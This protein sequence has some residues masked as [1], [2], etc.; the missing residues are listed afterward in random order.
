M[1]DQSNVI[2]ETSSAIAGL[3][4][5]RTLNQIEKGKLTYAL[6]ATIENFDGQSVNYQNEPGNELCFELPYGY[7]YNGG[8]FIPELTKHIYFL[9][10]PTTGDSEIGYMD[11]NNC[12]YH[13]YINDP[14]LAFDKNFPILKVAHRQTDCAT[15]IYW[16]DAHNSRRFLDLNN[17]P[18]K[19]KSG[20]NVCDNETVS[21]IDCNKLRIQP[22]YSIPNIEIKGIVNGGTLLAGTVQFGIQYSDA[23]GNPYTQYYSITNPTPI[24]NKNIISANFNYPVGKSVILN[25]TDIE[26]SGYYEYFNLA[27]IKTINDITSVELIGTYF[28]DN[29]E[30]QIIYNGQNQ[31]QI[32]L[33][34]DDVFRK[35]P[36]YDV[37]GDLTVV[38]DVIVWDQLSSVERVN[39]QKIANQIKLQWQTWRIPADEDYTDEYNATN[40][41]GQLRDEVYPYEIVFLLTNGKETDGFH[42]PGRKLSPADISYGEVSPSNPDFI[43]TPDPDTGTSPYW[44]IYN[45]ATV[46]ETDPSYVPYSNYKGPY[47]AGDFSYWESTELYPCNEEVWGE[48]AN[49]PIRHH[50]FPDVLISPI[51]ENPVIEINPDGTYGNLAIQKNA[52]FPI[53]VRINAQEIQ[54]LI[55]TSELTEEEKNQIVGFKIVRG[56]RSTNKSIIAKGILR[57]VGKYEREGTE[58]YFPNYPYNDLREDPFLLNQ[59]N[60]YSSECGTYT[61]T[62]TAD[63]E[64][65]FTNCFK[66]TPDAGI[67]FS[68]EPFDVCS[69]TKPVIL[70][71]TATIAQINFDT[72]VIKG[73][74]DSVFKIVKFRYNKFPKNIITESAVG[75]TGKLTIKVIK[76]STIQVLGADGKYSITQVSN[77]D[78]SECYPTRLN[79]F[80]SD[81]SK[82][83]HVFNSPETSFGQPFLGSVLKV[84]NVIFGSGKAHYTE[85]KKNAL[86]KLLTREAQEDALASSSKIADITGDFSSTAMF[87][88]Y[89]AYL[90]IYTN[91]ITRRN[92]GWSYNS[93]LDYD[94]YSNVNNGVGIK[95]RSLSNYQYLYPGVQSVNDN[96]NIN[97][98]QRE[99]SVYL[100]TNESVIPLPYPSKTSS[101]LYGEISKIEDKSRFI[102]SEI[103]CS[104]PENQFDISSVLYYASIKDIL[105]NQWGQ[106][107]SYETIDTGL[108]VKFD[109]KAYIAGES[110]IKYI[111]GGDTFI[112]KFSFKS[113]LPFFI[114]NRVNAPDDSDIYYD[115][116]GNIAYPEYWHSARSILFDYDDSRTSKLKNIISIKAHNFDCPNNQYP[117][118]NDD[119]DPP[120]VNP[121]RTF[122]DGKMYMF[123]YGIPTFHVE[124]SINVELRQAVNNREGDFYPHVSSGIPDDWVQ[125]SF[126]PIVQDNTYIYNVTYSKQNE[127]NFFSHLPVDFSGDLCDT[128]YPYRAIFSEDWL[129]YKAL[130]YF[131]FPQ[132]FGKLTSIDG[133]E[134]RSILARFENKSLLYNTLLTIDTSNPKA[135]Y[136]GGGNLFNSSPPVDFAETDL[137]YVGSQNKFLLKLPQGQLTVDAKRGQVFLITG[138]TANDI[139]GFESGL[140]RFLKDHLPFEILNYFSNIN[141]DNHFNGIGLHGVYDSKY[142]RVIITK[143]DYIPTSNKV[144]YDDSTKEFY[145]EK[146]YIQY[147]TTLSKI[148]TKEV[149]YLTD[150]DYFCNKSWTLSFNLNTMS[151]I[152]FHSYVPNW[153]ISENNFFYSGINDGC[154]LDVLAAEI[155]IP[156]S[157]TTTTTS[158]YI[159][160]CELE[161]E[162]EYGNCNLDGHAE[163][164]GECDL[165]GNAVYETTT[166][167]TTL[168][169]TTT[170]TTTV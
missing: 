138:N 39:Y 15:E 77:F 47:Q 170:T 94:Y 43:G 1:A 64:Y 142:N 124:S 139:S 156:P 80:D 168:A 87:T 44:K 52:I 90:Q 56:N 84:E 148:I 62:P 29:T 167:T 12:V 111:F 66:N 53:G 34:V 72:Y 95:Q 91:G 22:N 97:N 93:I 14:C 133:I 45:T 153:Y 81:D 37:A 127:E 30:K 19:I 161:G 140:N 113:K 112:S 85:V 16:T 147:P 92:Y 154:D 46:D 155:I 27:V 70:T 69:I 20:T 88:A 102:S 126:V 128:L 68:G 79:A 73:Y 149:V 18:Y 28:I 60:S 40:L 10:N 74:M 54:S 143:L 63:G 8:H 103:D 105:P 169:P 49:T 57:N 7:V 144:K 59:S 121:D 83:R 35:Y 141:T 78:N 106:I 76:D 163:Y 116:I 26:I 132:N 118:P 2:R 151:W 36:F 42:I 110:P 166:T 48:L 99:T 107:Y 146:E 157:T 58:Y 150:K 17:L 101:L 152:S 23:D 82:Y 129:T 131:D 71:G 25:I 11:S 41:R 75:G 55:L 67:M 104:N 145:V 122:Y 51:F 164:A 160:E 38:Q 114:D 61:I 137:G 96:L 100:K 119:V 33:T 162:V 136:I 89:Q 13:T 3:N 9:V 6:N 50:K 135:A 117:I 108:Q 86:Y 5:D 130:D 115:E 159:A 4:M 165:S 32:R 24:A 125:E 109:N 65:Q 98:Y 21:E 31:T 123:A 120:V 158:I 134:N